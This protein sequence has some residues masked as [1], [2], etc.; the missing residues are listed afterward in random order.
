MVVGSESESYVLLKSLVERVPA[1]V[2][3]EWLENL[4]Q[5]IGV[6]D[7]VEYLAAAPFV[8]AAR[9]REIQIGGPDV[10]T[11]SEMVAGMAAALGRDVPR[12]LPTPRGIES[13]AVGTA[14]GSITRGD[15]RVAA[16]I[17]AGLATDTVVTD[18]SGAALFDI[19]PESYRL[20]LARAVEDEARAE[21]RDEAAVMS[22]RSCPASISTPRPKR[23][24]GW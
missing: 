3:P 2:H 17:T 6:Q 23:S 15:R 24:G 5:P 9:D 7:V 19:R 16:H 12:R 13:K 10:M 20:T 22:P 11:Y 14:A 21:E 18:A 1:M 4:T 8:E